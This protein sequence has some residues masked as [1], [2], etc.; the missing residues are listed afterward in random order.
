MNLDVQSM[1]MREQKSRK[2]RHKRRKVLHEL[3]DES[4]PNIQIEEQIVIGDPP[5]D[6][7]DKAGSPYYLDLDTQVVKSLAFEYNNNS[8]DKDEDG[9]MYESDED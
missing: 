5:A 3:N 1:V 4:D 9:T 2:S 8:S 7:K 6:E